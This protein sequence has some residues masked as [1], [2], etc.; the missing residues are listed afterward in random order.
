[1]KLMREMLQWK[2]VTWILCAKY[3]R[4]A[5]PRDF[6]KGAPVAWK[7]WARWSVAP[8]LWDQ[9]TFGDSWSVHDDNNHVRVFIM[10]T[11]NPC[12]H[13][14]T[15]GFKWTVWIRNGNWNEFQRTQRYCTCNDWVHVANDTTCNRTALY[16]SQ[17]NKS[18]CQE[19]LPLDMIYTS[20]VCQT[21]KPLKW[22]QT[23]QQS[24]GQGS[25]ISIRGKWQRQHRS[26]RTEQPQKTKKA[27]TISAAGNTKS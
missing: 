23:T 3:M 9:T 17:P 14:R 1:M 15:H 21:F 13:H 26:N 2:I 18:R 5:L 10:T 22:K 6:W 12:S 8:K 4:L 25:S 7:F 16:K 11:I 19:R 27:N 24:E 20:N